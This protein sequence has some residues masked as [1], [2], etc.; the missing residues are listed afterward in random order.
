MSITIVTAFFDIGRSSWTGFVRTPSDYINNFSHLAQL[1]NKM[2]IYTSSEFVDIIREIRGNRP[3]VIKEIDFH[4]QYSDIR[5]LISSIQS[6]DEFRSKINPKQ[7]TSPEYWNPDFV[8]I[9]YLK[10]SFVCDAIE[11]DCDSN[12][13]FSWIDFG[14]CRTKSYLHNVTSWNYPFQKGKI[15]LFH[16]IPIKSSD[17]DIVETVYNNTVYVAGGVLIG[18][19]DIWPAFQQLVQSS[20]QELLD[21]SMVD[22]DQVL[23]LMSYLR[24]PEM[25]ELHYTDGDWFCHFR[26][27]A[28]KN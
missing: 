25:F 24:C 23:Y 28:C 17:I 3:T 2:F 11:S 10:T 8:L 18:S 19:T 14:Y 4:N 13:L 20:F 15:H 22:D 16:L 21:K 5:K 12:D 7:I 26:D 27:Y 6:N 9:N 1:D